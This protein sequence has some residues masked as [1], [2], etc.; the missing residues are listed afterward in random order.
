M[1]ELREDKG[2]VVLFEAE[3]SHE[4]KIKSDRS[5]NIDNLVIH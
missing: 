3:G 5:F 2:S 4:N 1:F